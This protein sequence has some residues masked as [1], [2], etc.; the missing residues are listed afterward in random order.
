MTRIFTL[1]A[2]L[3]FSLVATSVAQNTT[4]IKGY[5]QDKNNKA[6]QS[7]SVSFANVFF[8]YLN[9]I[10]RY[11]NRWVVKPPSISRRKAHSE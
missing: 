11:A 7:V 1:T 6:L 5:V 3:L 8:M 9:I 10:S 4:S 2:L